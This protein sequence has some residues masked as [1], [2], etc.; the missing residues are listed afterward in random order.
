MIK[1][2]ALQNIAHETKRNYL[3][4]VAGLARYYHRSPD[5]LTKENIEDYILYTPVITLPM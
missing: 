1:A 2:L 3:Q 5:T 4:S